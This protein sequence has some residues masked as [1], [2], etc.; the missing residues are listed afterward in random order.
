MVFQLKSSLKSDQQPLIPSG[1]NMSE[2]EIQKRRILEE[3]NKLKMGN[4]AGGHN[5]MNQC[6]INSQN[7]EI[8]RLKTENIK[9]NEENKRLKTIINDNAVND[10]D[11]TNEVSNPKEMRMK[12]NFL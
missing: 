10:I 5:V 2:R 6:V 9:L 1:D 12:I 8:E 7:L 4:T 11:S 3:I